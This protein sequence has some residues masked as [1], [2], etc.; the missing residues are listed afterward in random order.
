MGGE[1]VVDKSLV[2]IFFRSSASFRWLMNQVSC[3][4]FNTT[5]FRKIMHF[6][7]SIPKKNSIFNCLSNIEKRF[8]KLWKEMSLQQFNTFLIRKI[9]VHKF[10]WVRSGNVY[11]QVGQEMHNFS[12]QSGKL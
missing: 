7:F 12:E 3:Y 8:Q 2:L 6:M 1:A 9:N 10:S 4:F 11:G 5:P